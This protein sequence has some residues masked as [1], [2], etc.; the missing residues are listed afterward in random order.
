MQVIENYA[1]YKNS[2]GKKR[3]SQRQLLPVYMRLLSQVEDLGILSVEFDGDPTYKQRIEILK[4]IIQN[5]QK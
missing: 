2:K 4:K 3:K 1:P 5:Y